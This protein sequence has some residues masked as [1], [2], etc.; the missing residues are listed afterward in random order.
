MW[1][2]LLKHHLGGIYPTLSLSCKYTH[3]GHKHGP[4]LALTPSVPT[5][6]PGRPSGHTQENWYFSVK[7]TTSFF[8]ANYGATT[9]TYVPMTSSQGGGVS[10]VQV[11]RELVA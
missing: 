7:I 2:S 3:A 5:G 6:S 4:I 1:G 11:P 9:D 8:F 10:H